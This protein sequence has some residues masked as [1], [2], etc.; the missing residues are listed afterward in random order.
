MML[1]F[2]CIEAVAAIQ[3]FVKYECVYTIMLYD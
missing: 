1:I 3:R 2:L